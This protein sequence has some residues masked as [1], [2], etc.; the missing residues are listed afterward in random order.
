MPYGK[1][2]PICHSHSCI[3]VCFFRTRSCVVNGVSVSTTSCGG[4]NNSP[5]SVS[6][7]GSSQVESCNM[8]MCSQWSSWSSD[9]FFCS[10]SC[11]PAGTIGRRIFYRTCGVDSSRALRTVQERNEF[12]ECSRFPQF[13]V[14]ILQPCPTP[15]TTTTESSFVTLPTLPRTFPPTL[16]PTTTTS[17]TTT[18]R[19]IIFRPSSTV[20]STSPP[21]PRT[22]STRQPSSVVTQPIIDVVWSTWTSC[23]ATC[24]PGQSTRFPLCFRR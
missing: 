2:G 21:T 13:G 10:P 6:Q 4:Q 16:L 5:S 3:L 9:A 17:T 8:F 19:R 22:F 18:T 20:L 15:Q 12:D 24:G 23:S 7:E 14:C 1:S 11:G